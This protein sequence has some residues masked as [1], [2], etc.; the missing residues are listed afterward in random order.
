[1]LLRSPWWLQLGSFQELWM[2][3]WMVWII[4]IQIIRSSNQQFSVFF[5]YFLRGSGPNWKN[6]GS[7]EEQPRES[8]AASSK[9]RIVFVPFMVS[10]LTE[11]IS[12]DLFLSTLQ[13]C[14]CLSMDWLQG[15]S[16]GNIRKPWFSPSN[17][18]LSCEFSH[19]PILWKID[20]R[21][22]NYDLM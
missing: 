12:Q 8:D 19:H 3:K 11:K 10:L 1:V 13:C 17:I 14:F 20:L 2:E 7:L 6:C 15:K 4:A 5:Q 18:G 16:T 21:W 22:S 9:Y